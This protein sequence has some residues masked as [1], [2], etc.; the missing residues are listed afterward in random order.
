MKNNLQITTIQLDLVWENPAINY[1]RVEFYLKTISTGQDII[2]L[3]EMFT[4]GFSMNTEVS[5]EFSPNMTSLIRMK[6]WS[7][8]TDAAIV[9]SI[10]VK[11][12]SQFYNRLFF[13]KPDGSYVY[14]DKRHLFRLS[15]ENKY[16]TKGNKSVV[17]EWRSWRIKPLICYDLR[18]PLWSRN[19]MLENDVADF[20]LLIY[21][22]S[23]PAIRVHAWKS[24]LLA[25]AIENQVYC[26]G[27]NR[28]GKDGDGYEYSGDS[29]V[30]DPLGQVIGNAGNSESCL[31]L[32]L[33]AEE[34]INQRNRFP[35]LKDADTFH[36][37]D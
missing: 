18:F 4:T 9:G 2:I 17:V 13:V 8:F 22:A 14:Y 16:F 30:Y 15:D 27:A 20:D 34:L 28:C 35:V 29:L 32:Q 1:E 3:P 5:E 7:K 11:E 21:V 25:R 26:I 37:R 10:S 19:A 24:L 23:W 33:N 12:G 31:S 36:I 6:E